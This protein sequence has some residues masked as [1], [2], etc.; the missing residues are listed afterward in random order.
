MSKIRPLS[1]LKTNTATPRINPLKQKTLKATIQKALTTKTLRPFQIRATTRIAHDA[2]SPQHVCAKI[3]FARI[4]TSLTAPL[5]RPHSPH[6]SLSILL[7]STVPASFP[8]FA[9]GVSADVPARH[10]TCCL[11]DPCA[12]SARDCATV[13]PE[14]FHSYIALYLAFLPLVFFFLR[15]PYSRSRAAMLHD[16]L[17]SSPVS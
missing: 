14:L 3:D 1:T 5:R 15:L 17:T 12:M 4:S 13:L 16:L 9:T 11:H 7:V 8:L 2:S 10:L 6:V